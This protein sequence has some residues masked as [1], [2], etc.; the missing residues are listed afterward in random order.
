MIQQEKEIKEFLEELKNTYEIVYE[1]DDQDY[2]PDILDLCPTIKP[3]ND[4]NKDGCPDDETVPIYDWEKCLGI[5]TG[6]ASSSL[7]PTTALNVFGSSVIKGKH[8]WRA[9]NSTIRDK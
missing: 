2:V 7:Y 6:T 9:V 4:T 8:E 3:L 5:Y 1:D